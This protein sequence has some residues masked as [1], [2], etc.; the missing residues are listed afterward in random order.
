MKLTLALT[1]ITL[2][3]CSLAVAQD[4]TGDR[5]VVPARNSTRPRK[6]DVSIMHG[7][8]TVK[9]YNGKDVIVESQHSGTG[10]SRTPEVV[11]G[12]HRIDLPGRGLSVE[13][14]DNVITVRTNLSMSPELVISV[15]S[16][17]SLKLHTMHGD[18][19]V[20]GVN[21]EIDVN[22]TNGHVK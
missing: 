20:D 11:D 1:G 6:L 18:L 3:V 13:E 4:T 8:V 22:T 5:V 14:E 17:T 2:A 7:S 15:P 19:N 9:A 16:D 12:M 21:G 10:R